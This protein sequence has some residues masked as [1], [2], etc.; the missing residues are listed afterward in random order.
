MITAAVRSKVYDIK[1]LEASL[2]GGLMKNPK[3][4]YSSTYEESISIG[5]NLMMQER[6]FALYVASLSLSRRCKIM[7]KD[8]RMMLQIK[9][10]TKRKN[11]KKTREKK[12]N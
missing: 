2:K 8:C 9:K 12:D 11:V 4:E 6:R 3:R 7:D 1:E 5:M 10:K